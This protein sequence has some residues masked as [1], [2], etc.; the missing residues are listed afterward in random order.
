MI[1]LDL[2]DLHPFSACHHAIHGYSSSH[3]SHSIKTV[4]L[5]QH[6][7]LLKSHRRNEVGTWKA[8]GKSGM[9][10]PIQ[11]TM[12]F[13]YYFS[14]GCRQLLRVE[15]ESLELLCR[16]DAANI[17]R[18]ITIMTIMITMKYSKH[19]LPSVCPAQRWHLS[20]VSHSPSNL[21]L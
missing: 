5:L 12:I 6:Y 11:L 13:Y 10:F 20:A 4:F 15:Q 16:S 8:Q 18:T 14:P 3:S 2:F 21:S 19:H 9:L 1:F 17:T 7:F